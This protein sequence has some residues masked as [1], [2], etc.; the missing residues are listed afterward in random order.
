MQWACCDGG[1]WLNCDSVRS[2][3]WNDQEESCYGSSKVQLNQP[4]WVNGSKN[5][6][7]PL[8]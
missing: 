8:R 2:L 1:Q 4:S 6:K 5:E 3:A 7:G